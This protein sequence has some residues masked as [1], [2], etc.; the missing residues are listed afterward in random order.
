VITPKS[1]NELPQISI[2]RLVKPHA[3]YCVDILKARWL[4]PAFAES[5]RFLR[6]AL[7]KELVA[8]H[9]WDAPD[10]WHNWRVAGVR[11]AP[12]TKTNVNAGPLSSLYFGIYCYL[13]SVDWCFVAFFAVFSDDFVFFIP[14]IPDL[15]L[16]LEYFLSVS[17]WA[18]QLRV[19]LATCPPGSNL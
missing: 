9:I 19:T 5:Y 8:V 11:S 17:Q 2:W 6:V 7:S 12:P 13:V 15:L 3:N 1:S 10:H 14:S 18:V 16:F 4:G